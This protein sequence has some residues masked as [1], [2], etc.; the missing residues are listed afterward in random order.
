[1]WYTSGALNTAVVLC[2]P[3][4]LLSENTRLPFL[5]YVFSVIQKEGWQCKPSHDTGLRVY[6]AFAYASKKAK[7]KLFQN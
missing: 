1:M 3:S 2:G 4:G 5:P 6:S 7:C